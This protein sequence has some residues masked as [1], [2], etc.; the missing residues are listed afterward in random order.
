MA[1]TR[2]IRVLVAIADKNLGYLAK[3]ATYTV[4]EELAQDW[5]TA[6]YALDEV[7]AQRQEVYAA[8]QAKAEE[9]R[10]QAEHSHLTAILRGLGLVL[11]VSAYDCCPELEV[12]FRGV[13]VYHQRGDFDNER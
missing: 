1:E 5:I 4:P 9:G 10:R 13:T 3:G 6:G 11:K 8:Q 2:E 7:E 12:R